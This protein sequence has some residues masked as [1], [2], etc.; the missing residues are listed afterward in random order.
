V[1]FIGPSLPRLEAAALLP[2]RYMPPIRR[3]DLDAIGPAQVLVI[4]DGEFHQNLA[5]SPTEILERLDAGVA[6]FGAS[7]MGAIR[8]AE[9][10]PMGMVGIGAI[11]EAYRDGRIDGDDEVALSYC[12]IELSP[13]TVP[14]VNV[15]FWLDRVE[16]VGLLDPGEARALLR[17]AR[18]VF[19]ADRTAGRLDR[20]IG[21]AMGPDRLDRLRALG[22]DEIPDA[23]ADDARAALETVARLTLPDSSNASTR[24]GG[25]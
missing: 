11:F 1:V 4:I 9:L 18:R 10:S 19:Y 2:A 14:L 7:S 12:P 17:R 20:L 22:L 8:A 24:G 6:V 15:R 3:H 16:A 23:K 21:E 13:L 25:R 5:V